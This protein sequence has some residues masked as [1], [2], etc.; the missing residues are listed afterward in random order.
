MIAL[1]SLLLVAALVWL[2]LPPREGQ[3]WA[4]LLGFGLT[5]AWLVLVALQRGIAAELGPR[6]PLWL[7]VLAVVAAP[8]IQLLV[9]S[10]VTFATRPR[11][12]REP[13][14]NEDEPPESWER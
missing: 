3:R 9:W 12:P 4:L 1:G 5:V 10:V 6:G 13:P 2:S 8:L 14:T 7:V 11:A